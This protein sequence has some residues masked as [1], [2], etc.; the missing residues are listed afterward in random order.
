LAEH[1]TRGALYTPWTGIQQLQ[2][3][4]AA[5]KLLNKSKRELNTLQL[6]Q[7]QPGQGKAAEVRG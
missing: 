3:G 1:S 4:Q 7:L 2:V 6:A 5:C